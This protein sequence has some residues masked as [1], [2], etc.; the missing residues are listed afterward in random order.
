MQKLTKLFLLSMMMLSAFVGF[1][2]D[3]E[4]EN[5]FATNKPKEGYFGICYNISGLIGDIAF[6]KAT[7]ALNNPFLL[8]RYYFKKDL[9]FRLGFGV[10]SNNSSSTFSATGDL[11]SL[12]AGSVT[13]LS[14]GTYT[15]TTSSKNL[16]VLLAPGAEM[17]FNGNK[18]LDPYVGAVINILLAGKTDSST[19]DEWISTAA[20]EYS[21]TQSV[22]NVVPGG[23]GFGV[24]LIGGFNF[25]VSQHI[26]IGGECGWGFNRLSTGG[27]VDVTS[28]FGVSGTLA[29]ATIATTTTT[30]T[31]EQRNSSGGFSVN[32]TAAVKVS[33]F[34]GT[35]KM[36]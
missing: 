29:S 32:G 5:P 21:E 16:N 9:V 10:N 25:F 27:D 1:A 20:G 35:D 7:D 6:Q 23:L 11:T 33:I 31:F 24:N 4:M 14:Q 36:Q 19:S 3:D 34:F 18:R 2:Q 15:A 12:G 13:G 28:T 8:G 17:H 30:T 26:A 22:S